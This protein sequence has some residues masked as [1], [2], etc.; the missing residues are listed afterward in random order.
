MSKRGLIWTSVYCEGSTVV[1]KESRFGKCRDLVSFLVVVGIGVWVTYPL[2]LPLPVEDFAPAFYFI[3]ILFLGHFIRLLYVCLA[4]QKVLCV[5]HDA[6]SAPTFNSVSAS[7]IKHLC[8]RENTRRDMFEDSP[9]CQLY[10]ITHM[11]TELFLTQSRFKES[12]KLL[13]LAIK[14]SER[15]GVKIRYSGN[16]AS[17]ITAVL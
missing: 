4:T 6:G 1:V 13:H 11:G 8:I 7:L 10:A 3:Y 12:A 16:V 14:L 5:I 2:P 9:R 15:W 17:K